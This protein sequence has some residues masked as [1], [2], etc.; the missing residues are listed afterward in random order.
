MK[1]KKLEDRLSFK[2]PDLFLNGEIIYTVP[3]GECESRI[4][5]VGLKKIEMINPFTDEGY[6]SA[7]ETYIGS[8][9]CCHGPITKTLIKP[10][11]K[12]HPKNW[13]LKRAN[14]TIPPFNVYDILYVKGN[15]KFD[16]WGSDE[17]LLATGYGC[18]GSGVM[19]TGTQNPAL[20][21]IVGFEE[22]NGLWNSRITSAM[23][24]LYVDNNEKKIKLNMMKSGYRLKPGKSR[25]PKLPSIL[26]DGHAEEWYVSDRDIVSSLDLTERLSNLGLDINKTIEANKNYIR[27]T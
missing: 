4:N 18:S 22:F 7:F 25:D 13:I 14:V 2:G 9:G 10:K 16:S 17:G 20:I 5:I 11:D 15:F 1:E 8:G 3:F 12:E 6:V 21:N 26:V 24:L 23:P 19:L 27:I